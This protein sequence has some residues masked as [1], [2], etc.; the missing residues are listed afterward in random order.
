VPNKTLYV[1]DDDLGIW[2]R[3]ESYARASRQ[4]VSVLVAA[5]LDR[6]ITPG[7][8]ATCPRCG[9]GG[10]APADGRIPEHGRAADDPASGT[11]RCEGSGQSLPPAIR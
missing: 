1:R 4:S 11:V 3:A 6:Y 8:A 10:D 7:P 9:L 2:E 5:A